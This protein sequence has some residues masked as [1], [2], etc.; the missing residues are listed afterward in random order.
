MAKLSNMSVLTGL[1]ADKGNGTV[2]LC[3]SDY[4]RK[5]TS[6]LEDKAYKKLKKN[7]ID[8]IECKTVLLKMAVC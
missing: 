4:N 7:P 3:T 2:V 5:I 1:P 8:S 6:L